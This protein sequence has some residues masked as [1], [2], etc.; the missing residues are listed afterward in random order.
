[1]TSTETFA[2]SLN[3]NDLIFLSFSSNLNT[4]INELIVASDNELYVWGS[5]NIIL[6]MPLLFLDK[7]IFLKV[8]IYWDCCYSLNENQ[9][10]IKSQYK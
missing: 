6:E 3:D 7:I 5:F 4:L 8:S 2:C 1:M 9:Y 10:N